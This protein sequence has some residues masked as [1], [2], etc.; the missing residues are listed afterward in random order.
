MT[1]STDTFRYNDRHLANRLE[2][3]VADLRDRLRFE[4]GRSRDDT[5]DD[6]DKI[7]RQLSR[8]HC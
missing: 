5:L 6:I 3:E 8:M 2:A 4:T 7:E 1:T